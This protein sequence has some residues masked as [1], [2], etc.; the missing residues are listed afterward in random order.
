MSK[1]KQLNKREVLSPQVVDQFSE[2]L[3]NLLIEQEFEKKEALHY[4]VMQEHIQLSQR[5]ENFQV[6]AKVEDKWIRVYKGTTVGYKKIVRLHDIETNM[7]KIQ[8]KDSRV[9]P[10]LHFVGVYKK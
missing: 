7:L 2:D 3:Y 6:Y 4:L 5:I 9:C 10:T 1:M 8:I